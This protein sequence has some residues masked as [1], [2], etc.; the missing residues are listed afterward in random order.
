MKPLTAACI[1]LCLHL[2]TPCGLFA[3]SDSSYPQAVR[4]LITLY[5][6]A[7]GEQSSLYNGREADTYPFVFGTTHPYLGSPSWTFGSVLYD[8]ILYRDVPLLYDLVKD[9][10][11]VQHWNKVTKVLLVP[12]KVAAFT[13]EGRRFIRVHPDSTGGSV[14]EGFYELL[15]EGKTSVLARKEKTVRSILNA[16]RMDVSV[17]AKTTY[18]VKQAGAWYEVKNRRAFLSRLKDRK[19]ELQRFIRSGNISF[20]RDFESALK[21]VTAYYNQITDVL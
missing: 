6:N 15:E 7:Q 21:T 16:G 8:G 9:E 2:L 5:H 18:Y 14:R 3:Q 17:D 1:S 10:L 13:L 12:H 19:A 20:D 4:H 11:L